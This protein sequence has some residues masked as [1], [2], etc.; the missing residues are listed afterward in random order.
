MVD[1]MDIK[2]KEELKNEDDSPYI[3]TKKES[4]TATPSTSESVTA[5]TSTTTTANSEQSSPSTAVT[6]SSPTR[7]V[8]SGQAYQQQFYEAMLA[9]DS[10]GL[11]PLMAAAAAAMAA[12]AGVPSPSSS[13]IYAQYQQ[14][15]QQQQQAQP[16]QQL[17]AQ[18]QPEICNAEKAKRESI[19]VANRERKKKWR[20]H[21]VERNK[22]NDLRCR[23]NK[24]AS[25]LFGNE[26]TD[27]KE[28]WAKDE[29]EKRREKRQEKE[30][31]KDVVDNV[32]SV[33]QTNLLQQNAVDELAQSLAAY[34]SVFDASK[35][36]EIPS[37]LQRHLLEQ[38]NLALTNSK[39]PSH[40]TMDYSQQGNHMA[41]SSTGPSSLSLSSSSQQQQPQATSK[42]TDH[43]DSGTTTSTNLPTNVSESATA[44]QEPTSSSSSTAME[45]DEFITST[46]NH[47]EKV[48]IKDE[49][50]N[51]HSSGNGSDTVPND[52]TMTDENQKD[53]TDS[54]TKQEYP[55]DAVLTLMQMNS[56][57]KN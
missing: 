29:F 19:R 55:M 25:K 50:N 54:N 34:P 8:F 33:P 52:Q 3:E 16:H 31:R 39:L 12:A 51:G 57:W 32:L 9:Q 18:P 37:D 14:Q 22:D 56:G 53:V 48:T 2:V 21:N 6:S 47:T 28:R 13:T 24:R 11:N 27:T 15:Q 41:E 36:L 38:L 45:T 44:T 23:V 17:Q 5:M 26:D 35:L 30:R 46:E 4:T 43:M 7:P 49:D 42:D 40:P 20:I 10:H 1:G